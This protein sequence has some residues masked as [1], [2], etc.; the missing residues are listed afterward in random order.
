MTLPIDTDEP[1]NVRF[2]PADGRLHIADGIPTFDEPMIQL[3]HVSASDGEPAACARYRFSSSA[4]LGG[5]PPV[6]T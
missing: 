5:L 1:R 6:K 3:C 4:K 2:L